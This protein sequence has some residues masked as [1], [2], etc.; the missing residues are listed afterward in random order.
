MMILWSR[1]PK[2]SIS[3]GLTDYL[4]NENSDGM[5]ALRNAVAKVV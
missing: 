3:D 4:G 1:R 2:D 5:R